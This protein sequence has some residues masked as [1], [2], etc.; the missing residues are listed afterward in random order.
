MEQVKTFIWHLNLKNSPSLTKISYHSSGKNVSASNWIFIC[1]RK[2]RA[3]MKNIWYKMRTNKLKWEFLLAKTLCRWIFN[4]T[5]KVEQW[6]IS[7]LMYDGRDAFEHYRKAKISH[8]LPEEMPRFLGKLTKWLKATF[9]LSLHHIRLLIN[10]LHA[11]VN[12][13]F[14]CL[15]NT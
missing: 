13:N 3:W 6:R 1:P 10:M 7:Y 12:L 11:N 15:M 8:N 14:T 4:P 2:F 5:D 9:I